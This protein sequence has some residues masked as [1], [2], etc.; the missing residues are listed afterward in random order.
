[1]TI[2][3]HWEQQKAYIKRLLSEARTGGLYRKRKI[4]VDQS[5]DF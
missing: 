2:N 5:L 1:M 3:E 4:D